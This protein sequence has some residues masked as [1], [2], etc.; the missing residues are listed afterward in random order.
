VICSDKTGTL[1]RNEM[2]V[3]RVVTPT[4]C[5]KSAASAMRPSG[6]FSVDDAPIGVP[7]EAAD[8]QAIAR[9]ARLCND[10]VLREQGG[11]WRMEGDPTEGALLT[12]PARP[13]SIQCR[14]QR[15]SGA[16]T[17]SPSNPNTASWP[18]CT[19]IITGMVSFTSRARRNEF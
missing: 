9:A 11:E 13:A 4:G 19:T 12:W 3:Q 16:W 8:L 17:A 7:E 5:S 1:T 6:G 10:A 18:P 14:T 15:G 2:T